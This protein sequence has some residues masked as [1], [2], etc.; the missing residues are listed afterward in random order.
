MLSKHFPVCGH[1]IIVSLIL[2]PLGEVVICILRQGSIFE[3]VVGV[4]IGWQRVN[5]HFADL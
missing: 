2:C 3:G 1:S 4:V 5:L